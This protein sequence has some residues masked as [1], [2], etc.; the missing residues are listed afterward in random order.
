ML[1]YF[2]RNIHAAKFEEK[3]HIMAPQLVFPYASPITS[4]FQ[5]TLLCLNTKRKNQI[6]QPCI[7]WK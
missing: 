3:M 2:W 4:T 5:V 1:G 6:L 7:H